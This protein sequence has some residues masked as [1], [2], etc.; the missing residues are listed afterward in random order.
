MR[1]RLRGALQIAAVLLFAV[2]LWRFFPYAA[3]FVEGA[4]LN[5]RRFWWVILLLILGG[6]AVW[7]LSKRNPL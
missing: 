5:L 2:L 6:W 4:A 7:V 3:S 1:N